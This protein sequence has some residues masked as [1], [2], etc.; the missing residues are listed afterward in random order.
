MEQPPPQQ[1]S[2]GELGKAP[3]HTCHDLICQGDLI[4]SLSTLPNE[5][6]LQVFSYVDVHRSARVL[7]YIPDDPPP[8]PPDE[9][10]VSDFR[11]SCRSLLGVALTCRRFAVL[12]PEVLFSTLVLE[13]SIP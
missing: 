2:R 13:L 12:I 8:S 4:N 1:A 3:R 7:G 11:A 6:L 9:Y 10:L 5:I